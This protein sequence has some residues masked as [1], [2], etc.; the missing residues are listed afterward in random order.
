M[1]VQV[2][3]VVRAGGMQEILNRLMQEPGQSVSKQNGVRRCRLAGW[4]TRAAMDKTHFMGMDCV[5][6]GEMR[7]ERLKDM[8]ER[9]RKRAWC[10][11]S[12]RGIPVW[13][14]RIDGACDGRT[15]E[16]DEV[17]DAEYREVNGGGRIRD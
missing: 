7:M 13:R 6:S 11:Y 4:R 12:Y 10:P 17:I 8:S 16:D 3:S 14:H 5:F 15:R 2:L 1:R 9:Y